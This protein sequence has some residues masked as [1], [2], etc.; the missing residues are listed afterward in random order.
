MK[1]RMT[2][3]SL[4]A[5]AALGLI[6][7]PA[8]TAAQTSEKTEIKTTTETVASEVDLL[9]DLWQMEDA[10]PVRQGQ[11]DLRFTTRWVTRTTPYA[12]TDD[13]V[14]VQPAIVWGAF[15]NFELSTNV[16]VWL[17]DAGDAGP[18]KDGNADTNVGVLWRFLEPQGIWPAMALGG[19]MRI[20]TGSRSS[21]VDGEVRLVLTNEYDS[22]IRSHINGLLRTVNG[23]NDENA[24]HFQWGIILGLDGPL[25]AGGA[26]RW[27]AD[28]VHRSS[29][30]YGASNI[31]LLEL[32]WEWRIAEAHALGMSTQIGLDDNEDTPNFGATM[33][34][35]YSILR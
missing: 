20:P 2:L 34:Y 31:N 3:V 26:V 10:R 25:C 17:G 22:G 24:R 27:L 11:V 14:I 18:N 1:E 13:D 4:L 29:E 7:G 32:G 8:T 28:Y 15:Q 16:P 23:N 19:R 33:T 6:I 9:T 12:D 21:G 35:A 5:I 30:H